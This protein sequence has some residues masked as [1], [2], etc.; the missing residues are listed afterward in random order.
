MAWR[1]GTWLFT[2]ARCYGSRLET[3]SHTNPLMAALTLSS[4][5]F[6]LCAMVPRLI[7]HPVFPPH[8]SRFNKVAT[9]CCSSSTNS[10][11][12]FLS[13]LIHGADSDQCAQS[14][15]YSMCLLLKR[16]PAIPSSLASPAHHKIPRE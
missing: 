11:H 16:F 2:S 7:L 10:I 13:A 5:E 15:P 4:P 3:W 9:P 1:V 14:P 12:H 8:V 6:V